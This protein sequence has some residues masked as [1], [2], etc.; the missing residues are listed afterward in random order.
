MLNNLKFAFQVSECKKLGFWARWYS[1]MARLF[2]S[3]K[4][5]DKSVECLDKRWEILMNMRSR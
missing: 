2:R 4:Y 1:L 3:R 5:L